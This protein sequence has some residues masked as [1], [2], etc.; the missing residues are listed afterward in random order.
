MFPARLRPCA[1]ANRLTYLTIDRPTNTACRGWDVGGKVDLL[2]GT[3]YVFLQARGFETRS[4]LSPKWNSGTGVGFDG[5]G[6][7]GLA[8]P[9]FYAQVACHDASVKFGRF[10]HPAGF[11]GFDPVKGVMGNT[12]TYTLI[13]NS[14][15]PVV[16]A[17]ANGKPPID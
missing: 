12:N 5:V 10:Y 3:D 6:L 1:A 7:M 17:L 11:I 8:M 13:Y 2:Y 4:D 15:L 16:G 14:I 9:Q